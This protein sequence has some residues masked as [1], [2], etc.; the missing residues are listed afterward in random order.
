MSSKRISIEVLPPSGLR[1]AFP[2]TPA[3]SPSN[4]TRTSVVLPLNFGTPSIGTGIFPVGRSCRNIE[5]HR[6]AVRRP[7]NESESGTVNAFYR[8]KP[9]LNLFVHRVLDNR[10]RTVRINHD[11]LAFLSTC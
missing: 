9:Y 4:F 11:F 6:G 8:Q 5:S 10:V 3:S 7:A 2:L 1:Y